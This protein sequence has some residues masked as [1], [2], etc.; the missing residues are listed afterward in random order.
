MAIDGL[1]TVVLDRVR[2]QIEE[3]LF[4]A[5]A[6]SG[7]SWQAL[8]HGGRV[9]RNAIAARQM[10]ERAHHARDRVANVYGLDRNLQLAALAQRQIQDFVD[11]PQ[12]ELP[13]LP[14]L[15]DEVTMTRRKRLTLVALK[16]LRKAQDG[17]QR[18]SELV[19]H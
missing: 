12:Q 8:R 1:L 17:V 16:Q 10:L 2:A 11:E 15:L 7:D 4:E 6:V 9:Q 18:G 3:N 19:A 13:G 5:T 14:N